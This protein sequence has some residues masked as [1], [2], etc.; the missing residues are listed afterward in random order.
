MVCRNCGKSDGHLKKDCP[1]PVRSS[2]IMAVKCENQRHLT[3]MVRRR[4]SLSFMEYMTGVYDPNNVNYLAYLVQNMC[5]AERTLLSN[6]PSYEEA[7]RYAWNMGQPSSQTQRHHRGPSRMAF[8]A[9]YEL[10]KNKVSNLCKKCIPSSFEPEWGW[11][12]GRREKTDGTDL[13]CAIR[14]FCEETGHKKDQLTIIPD[15]TLN[16]TFVGSNGTRY[17]H[18][19]YVAVLKEGSSRAPVE[20]SSR[21]IGSV[22][23]FEL[24]DAYYRIKE[25]NIERRALCR[26]L[27]D[28]LL[29]NPQV[30]HSPSST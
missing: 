1:E 23:W 16:E 7:W 9:I 15:F 3:L 5:D 2:G 13:D 27:R 14:E 17:M 28:Y 19:Y 12:K 24:D 4:N 29:K 10:T 20:Y 18:T 22:R 21:E 30:F 11:P 26:Q 6:Q 8:K 25:R